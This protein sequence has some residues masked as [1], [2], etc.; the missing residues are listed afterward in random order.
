MSQIIVKIPSQSSGELYE[1]VFLESNGDWKAACSCPATAFCKHIKAILENNLDGV[2]FEPS[3]EQEL[4]GFLQS[5]FPK[6]GFA[7]AFKEYQSAI[8]VC[9]QADA[10]KKKKASAL[11]KYLQSRY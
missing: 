2:V 8:F 4:K 9:E 7:A 11:K 1:V 6:S 10:A 3:S 5:D